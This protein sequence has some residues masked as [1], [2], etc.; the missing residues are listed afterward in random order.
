MYRQ[1]YP[2]PN[3]IK[4]FHFIQQFPIMSSFIFCPCPKSEPK[5]TNKS[6]DSDKKFPSTYIKQL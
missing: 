2:M 5:S 4:S 6:L 3:S 1:P